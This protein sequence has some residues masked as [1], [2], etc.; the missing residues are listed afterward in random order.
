MN[1]KS[2]Q[3]MLNF[4]EQFAK[5]IKND[6]LATK[7]EPAGPIVIELIGD[8]GSGKTAVAASC[9]YFAAKTVSKAQ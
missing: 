4:G 6:S 5:M 1:I 8:V 3:E 2:E 7:K 9:M